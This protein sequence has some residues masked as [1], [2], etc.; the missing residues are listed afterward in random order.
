MYMVFTTKWFLEVAIKSWPGRDLNPHPLNSYQT[1]EPNKLS[2][3]W[4][5]LALRANFL[6]L[7]QFHFSVQCS[8][9]ISVVWRVICHIC[10]ER[11]LSQ[12]IRLVAEWIDTYENQHSRIFRNSYRKSVLVGFDPTIIELRS[13]ALSDWAIRSMI[14]T[15]SQGQLCRVCMYV[16][17]Y[18]CIL[19]FDLA[20]NSP[21]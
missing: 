10:I 18:V 6:Q 3:H 14:L 1:L 12:L 7:L 21:I 16:C 17:M 19:C 11:G 4:V 9:F 15:Q 2:G 5:Q 20:C 13:D 8:R